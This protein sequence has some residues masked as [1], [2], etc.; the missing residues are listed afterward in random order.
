MDEVAKGGQV[1]GWWEVG[2]PNLLL[3]LIQVDLTLDNMR[4]IFL[5]QFFLRNL[6][7]T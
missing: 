6:F 2:V 4:N 3:L 1:I 5:A 7:F